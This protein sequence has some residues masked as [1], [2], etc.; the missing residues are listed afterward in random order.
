M[1]TFS[2]CAFS[3]LVRPLRALNFLFGS[4]LL[5]PWLLEGETLS[6]TIGGMLAGAALIELALPRG[7][8]RHR[9]AGERM[10][11]W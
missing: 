4:C 3:E 8:V 9:Y 10:L 11:A 6:G 7:P 1:F 2:I 5:S